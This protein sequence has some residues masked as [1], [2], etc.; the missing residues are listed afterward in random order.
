M[1]GFERREEISF[2]IGVRSR[3]SGPSGI[4]SGSRK[5]FSRNGSTASS[6]SG[7]PSWNNTMPTRFFPATL[8]APV[9]RIFEAL[10][11]F[12]E[13]GGAARDGEVVGEENSPRDQVRR[14]NTVQIFH[15]ASD[16]CRRVSS[17]P[18]ADSIMYRARINR[19]I[20]ASIANQEKNSTFHMVGSRPEP[21]PPM[22]TGCGCWVRHQRMEPKTR[23]T[24]M[25]AKMPK[26]ALKS[27]RR[28]GSSTRVR[29]SRK[30]AYSS[31]RINVEVRRA[32]QVHQMPHT[33]CAQMGPV[34]STTLV[35]TRPTSAADTLS[36][37][38][39]GWRRKTY[40]KFATK[41][42]KKAVRP[43]QALETC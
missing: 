6:E 43:V 30:Q 7:P 20:S 9:Q 4:M 18:R 13:S 31:Q 38:H 23:G 35:K 40:S 5:R 42:M 24:S 36:Q 3:P 26:R 19:A 27:I 11:I 29:S 15:T 1:T 34:T 28:S 14:E 8:F 25:K 17:A 12:V 21:E 22:T 16:S 41:Q 2:A 10:D 32:S 37:S 33:G 39:C